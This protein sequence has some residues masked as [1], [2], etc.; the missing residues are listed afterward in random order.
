MVCQA[1]LPDKKKGESDN[2]IKTKLQISCGALFPAD[3]SAPREIDD[4]LQVLK[5]QPVLKKTFPIVELGEVSYRKEE[6]AHSPA[7]TFFTVL[8]TPQTKI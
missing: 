5:E 6:G 1:E 3:G 2:V 8:C 4:F 7:Q